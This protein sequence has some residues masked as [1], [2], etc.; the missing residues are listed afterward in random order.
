MAVA[1]FCFDVACMAE[2][3]YYFYIAFLAVTEYCFDVACMA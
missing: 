3:E 2:T 1:D